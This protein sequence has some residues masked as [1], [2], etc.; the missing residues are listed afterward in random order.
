MKVLKSNLL[1]YVALMA[2]IAVSRVHAT[3][4]EEAGYVG[5]DPV[6]PSVV[7]NFLKHFDYEAYVWSGSWHFTHNNDLPYGVDKFDFVFFCGHGDTHL[8]VVSDG[9]GGDG[10]IVRIAEM[11][12][13]GGLGDKDLEFIVFHSCKTVASPLET[14]NWWQPWR[15]VFNGL[16]QAVGFHTNSY[17]YTA[18]K[19][20]NSFGNRVASTGYV[21]QSWFNAIDE[22]GDHSS[23]RDYGCALMYP[24][25]KK[26]RYRKCVSC[27]PSPNHTDFWIVYQY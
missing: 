14:V 19:I 5:N 25:A 23:N 13:Q 15:N 24:P 4:T 26:D 21:W 22:H 20:A 2:C 18:E 1:I 12:G 3:E 6:A 8:I 10:R 16:H 17:K 27:D 11:A 9:R 7:W